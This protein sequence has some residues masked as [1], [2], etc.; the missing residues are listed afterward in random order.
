[1][2]ICDAML[3][4]AHLIWKF[5]DD[6]L[7]SVVRSTGCCMIC[8][9]CV[10]MM[11]KKIGCAKKN[12][13]IDHLLYMWRAQKACILDREDRGASEA[14]EW[15]SRKSAKTAEY[16]LLFTCWALD[17]VKRKTDWNLTLIPVCRGKAPM[18]SANVVA[19]EEKNKSAQLIEK[20][21][22]RAPN[23]KLT[24]GW[25]SWPVWNAEVR[26]KALLSW[27]KLIVGP[28]S[29]VPFAL[30]L[31]VKRGVADLQRAHID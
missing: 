30:N 28:N 1:M 5:G 9:S 18:K 19:A 8:S 12:C 23:K 24:Q 3:G 17:R 29:Q 11:S 21:R 26:G 10:S 15:A 20:G 14:M 6:L 25:I 22:F 27:K 16:S 13:R 4:Q 2:L 7:V 31:I